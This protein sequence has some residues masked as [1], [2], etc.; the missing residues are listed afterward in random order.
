MDCGSSRSRILPRRREHF[1]PAC[2]IRE[3]IHSPAKRSTWRAATGKSGCRSRCSSGICQRNGGQSWKL[4]GLA[5]G[6]TRLDSCWS[7]EPRPHGE[8]GAAGSNIDKVPFR[9][10]LQAMARQRGCVLSD[11][12]PLLSVMSC[13]FRK[14]RPAGANIKMRR[15]RSTG[16]VRSSAAGS[17]RSPCATK[18]AWPFSRRS[19]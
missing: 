10:C 15:R 16:T 6:R 14:L 12:A 5:T 11:T 3:S 17:R 19:C 4:C 8:S 1:P 9:N 18:P 7:A 13:L 2:T